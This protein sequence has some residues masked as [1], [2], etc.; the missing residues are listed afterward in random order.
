[1][2]NGEDFSETDLAEAEEAI[3]YSFRDKSLLKTCLTHSTWGKLRGAEDN[4]RLE[5]LGDAVLSLI[6]SNRLFRENPEASEG[7]LTALRQQYVSGEPLEAFCK[8]AGFMRFLRHSGGE[9]NLGAKTVS[10]LPEAIL[11]AV[12]L[13]GGY[14]E[15]QKFVWR[16]L[17]F[18]PSGNYR[19][20]LQEYVQERTKKTPVYSP[21]RE[22]NGKQHCVV[23]ALGREAHG[24]GDSK[25]TAETEA[26]EKLYRILVKEYGN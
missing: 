25:K 5:F 4:E 18:T 9:Q 1:M 6:V 3:G 22:E 17:E 21:C 24:S 8:R 14:E 19:T 15:A 2:R 10:S 16:Y 23:S 20:L 7:Q 12:Y 26:A 13:D 11:G